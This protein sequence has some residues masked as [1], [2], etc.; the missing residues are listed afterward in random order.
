[1]SFLVFYITHP[2]EATAKKVT[3]RLL[4]QRLV[5][6]ANIF[7]ITS[8]YWWERELQREEEWVT[9]VKTRPELEDRVVEAVEAMHPYE[10]P[11]IMRFEVRANAAYEAWIRAETE[12]SLP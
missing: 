1:M 5:A 9:L 7:P 8:A 2:D 10:V 11:C 4:E 3:D 12:Q 6:C